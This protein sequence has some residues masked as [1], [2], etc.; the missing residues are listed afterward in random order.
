MIPRWPLHRTAARVIIAQA[1][2]TAAPPYGHRLRIGLPSPVCA[3]HQPGLIPRVIH[4]RRV[5]A[6][7]AD[8][9]RAPFGWENRHA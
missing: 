2:R 1:S 3:D 5:R 7:Y 9:E 4:A 6:L 8:C